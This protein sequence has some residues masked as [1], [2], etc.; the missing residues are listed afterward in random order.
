[1]T[2]EE[3]IKLAKKFGNE[4]S[5]YED[6]ICLLEALGLVKFEEE[7]KEENFKY[8]TPVGE[9]YWI[10]NYKLINHLKEQGYTVTKNG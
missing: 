3:A 2:R 6:T 7:K 9:I 4:K 5:W 8:N 10:D 1:M